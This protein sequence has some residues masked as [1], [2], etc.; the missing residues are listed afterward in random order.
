MNDE[1]TISVNTDLGAVKE[2]VAA[3][4]VGEPLSA[5]FS[6]RNLSECLRVIND[7]KIVLSLSSPLSPCIIT[8][9]TDTSFTYLVMPIRTNR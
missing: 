5:G 2:D 1:I 9:E 3:V 6:T 4:I 7:E 8:G